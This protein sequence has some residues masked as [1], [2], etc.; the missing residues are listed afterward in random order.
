[1]K[2]FILLF[3][4]LT[5]GLLS[6]TTFAQVTFKVNISSQPMWGPVGYEYVE[7][8]YLPDIEVYYNVSS[9]RYVYFANNR[10]ISSSYLPHRYAN[11]DVYNSRKVV[12]NEHKPYMHHKDNKYRYNNQSYQHSNRGSI[13]DSH[14]ERYFQNKNHPE[15]YKYKNAQKSNAQNHKYHKGNNNKYNDNKYNDNQNKG[16]KHKKDN[17]KNKH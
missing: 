1:M 14:D 2:K 15:H 5:S 11:Y 13:R 7:Y 12:I 3:A 8:Y 17:G 6:Q 4:I 16:N 10:W 9:H